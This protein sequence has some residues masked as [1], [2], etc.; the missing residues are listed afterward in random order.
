MHCLNLTFR[1]GETIPACTVGS[2]ETESREAT[3]SDV[4]LRQQLAVHYE[5]DDRS[6]VVLLEEARHEVLQVASPCLPFVI[7]ARRLIED[8]LNARFA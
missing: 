5:G 1:G 7:G 4:L 3:D 6:P 2:L 8:V